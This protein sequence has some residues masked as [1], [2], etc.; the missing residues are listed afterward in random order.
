MNT[1]HLKDGIPMP[2]VTLNRAAIV[3]TVVASA[4]TREWLPIALLFA[5]LAPAAIIGKRASVIHWLG[6]RLLARWNELAGHEDERMM[7][8]NNVIA[9]GLLGFATLTFALGLPALG[10]AAAA[11]V[12]LAAFAALCGFCLGCALYLWLKLGQRRFLSA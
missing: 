3:L 5:V 10:W 1:S 4:V 6:S 12:A 2:I 8:F 11:M 7:R 9:A